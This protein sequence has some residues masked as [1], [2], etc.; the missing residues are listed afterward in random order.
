MWSIYFNTKINHVP[1]SLHQNEGKIDILAII[2]GIL[3]ALVGVTAG[4]AVVT[5]VE[6]VP[7]GIGPHFL[8]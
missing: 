6:A 5:P 7:I 8:C 1:Y 3:G 4:C 2:N